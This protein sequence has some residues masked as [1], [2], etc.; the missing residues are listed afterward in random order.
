[1]YM[2]S[3]QCAACFV[4]FIVIVDSYNHLARWANMNCIIHLI[5]GKGNPTTEDWQ[6]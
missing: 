4:I 3:T 6:N 5:L 2:T 1:M